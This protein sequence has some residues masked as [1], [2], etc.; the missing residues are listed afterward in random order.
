MKSRVKNTMDELFKFSLKPLPN[1]FH[2]AFDDRF[3][4]VKLLAQD[5]HVKYVMKMRK[6]KRY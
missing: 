2:L 6:L 3:N 4:A 1:N 5:F